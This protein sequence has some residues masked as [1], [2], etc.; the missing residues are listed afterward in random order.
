MSIP[1]RQGTTRDYM[2]GPFVDEEDGVTPLEELTIAD[3]DVRL[4]KNGGAWDDKADGGLTHT[5][6]G[7][8]SGTLDEDDTDTVGS[9]QLK[10]HAAGA[11]PVHY[12]FWVYAADEFDALFLGAQDEP[13]QGAPE[14]TAGIATKVAYLYK[15]WRNLSETLDTVYLLYSADGETVDQAAPIGDDGTTFTRGEMVSGADV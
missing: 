2:I 15:A 14:A 1:L 4:S 11:L 12:D 7:W 10:V 3:T 6:D 5:E 13:G 9:L 8:Y